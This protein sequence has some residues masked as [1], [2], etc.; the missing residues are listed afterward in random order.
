M[1]NF[2]LTTLTQTSDVGRNLG[3]V[4][5]AFAKLGPDRRGEILDALLAREKAQTDKVEKARVENEERNT[6]AQKTAADDLTMVQATIKSLTADLNVA[7]NDLDTERKLTQTICGRLTKM[8][9]DS[10]I[11]PDE[12]AEL[13]SFASA[14]EKTRQKQF[15]KAQLLALQAEIDK[16]P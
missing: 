2:I 5:D 10:I 3:T 8:L 12:L 6:K 7:R 9:K 4:V 1:S 11:S 14:D 15:K 13:Q 16:M